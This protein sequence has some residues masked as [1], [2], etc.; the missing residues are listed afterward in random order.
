MIMLIIKA[1]THTN[2]AFSFLIG[3]F[4]LF[5]C[6][7][8]KPSRPFFGDVD[9]DACLSHQLSLLICKHFFV[10]VA[11]FDGKF[12]THRTFFSIVKVRTGH[13]IYIQSTST[14]QR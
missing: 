2:T 9:F 6:M 13:S 1:E 10:A 12:E 7:I 5:I 4:A 14:M 11:H 3:E 8:K